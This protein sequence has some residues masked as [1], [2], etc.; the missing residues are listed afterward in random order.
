MSAFHPK[1]PSAF[2]PLRT[3]ALQS[4]SIPMNARRYLLA[5]FYLA[6]GSGLAGCDPGIN[7]SS[8][9]NFHGRVDTSCI[10]QAL[11]TVAPDVTRVTYVSDGYRGF[12]KGAEVTGLVILTRRPWVPTS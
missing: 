3:L 11:K 4:I 6:C 12:P 1:L 7:V 2:D 5:A 8:R 10:G 9:G